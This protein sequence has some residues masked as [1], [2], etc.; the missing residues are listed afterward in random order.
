MLRELFQSIFLHSSSLKKNELN[1]KPLSKA[2]LTLL[3]SKEFN[4]EG[5]STVR[6]V[7]VFQLKNSDTSK[8]EDGNY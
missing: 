6:D 4:N 8:D 3:E 1:K 7:F 5:L 2:E